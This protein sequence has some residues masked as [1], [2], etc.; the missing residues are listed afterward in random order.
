MQLKYEHLMPRILDINQLSRDTGRPNS[1]PTISSKV[2]VQPSLSEE[3]W[4]LVSRKHPRSLYCSFAPEPV[5]ALNEVCVDI[6]N[7]IV[8][9][10]KLVIIANLLATLLQFADSFILLSLN[11]NDFH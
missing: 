2:V 6:S 7:L 8:D 4:H 3:G 9:S 1:T 5:S 11:L 10:T